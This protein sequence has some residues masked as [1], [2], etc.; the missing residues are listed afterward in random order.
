M[1]KYKEKINR[2]YEGLHKEGTKD[3]LRKHIRI[4]D[5]MNDELLRDAGLD[6][7]SKASIL[8]MVGRVINELQ[9]ASAK[10]K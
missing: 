9:R 2:M 8:N 3:V 10:N 5:K 6:N 1:E 7:N 4:M